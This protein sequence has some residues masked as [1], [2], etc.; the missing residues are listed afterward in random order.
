M[1]RCLPLTLLLLAFARV[2]VADSAACDVRPTVERGLRYLEATSVAWKNAHGCASCHHAPIMLWSCYAA[3][4][5]GYNVS[6]QEY[7]TIRAWM[8]A[9]DNAAK[10]TPA[11]SFPIF[12]GDSGAL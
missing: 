8:T 6:G 5:Q 1:R 12:T 10:I 7:E 4:Q 3:K 9:E 2:A 11:A